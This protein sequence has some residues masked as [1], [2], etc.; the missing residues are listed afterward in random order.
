MLHTVEQDLINLQCLLRASDSGGVEGIFTAADES[1]EQAFA[2][3]DAG[4]QWFFHQEADPKA[5]PT[6]NDLANLS[7]LNTAESTVFSAQCRVKDLKWQLFALWWTFG[8]N[9]RFS[10]ARV[11]KANSTCPPVSSMHESTTI[12][13]FQ[14]KVKDVSD[15]L[16][17]SLT[18]LSTTLA[19][20]DARKSALSNLAASKQPQ[21]GAA[22]RFYQR[23]DPTILLGAVS[24]GWESDFSDASQVRLRDQSMCIDSRHTLSLLIVSLQRYF[25]LMEMNCP[26]GQVLRLYC[27]NGCKSCRRICRTPQDC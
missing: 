14:Q 11:V 23:S 21:R 4:T 13:V 27:T 20:R 18:V 25:R 10:T 15:A 9:H 5:K 8:T 2:K 7:Q 22:P 24:S 19:T 26:S 6:V 16:E 12:S 17:Q 1:Y 3:I